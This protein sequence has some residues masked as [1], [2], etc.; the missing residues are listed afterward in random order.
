[1]VTDLFAHNLELFGTLEIQ[2][3]HTYIYLPQIITIQNMRFKMNNPFEINT[4]A[5]LSSWENQVGTAVSTQML[6]DKVT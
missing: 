2:I 6:S 5:K 3:T 1:M 4:D